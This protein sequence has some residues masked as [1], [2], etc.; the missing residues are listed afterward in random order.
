MTKP[1]AKASTEKNAPAKVT[2]LKL[3]K[4][5]CAESVGKMTRLE[6][7]SAPTSLMPS[8]IKTE[9]RTANSALYSYVLMPMARANFSSKVKAKILL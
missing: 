7:S 1:I 9:Q 3:L 8:T 5:V 2:L 6:I 4:I